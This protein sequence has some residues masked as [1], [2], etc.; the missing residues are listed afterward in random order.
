METTFIAQSFSE[1]D[2]IAQILP[3]SPKDKVS[4]EK[5]KKTI[6]FICIGIM[7]CILGFS[8]YQLFFQDLPLYLAL[9][10][11]GPSLLAMFIL[12][13]LSL[14]KINDTLNHAVKHV[15][16]ARVISKNRTSSAYWL[17]LGGPFKDIKRIFVSAG[18][19]FS[20]QNNDLVYVEV[21][22]KSKALLSLRKPF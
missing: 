17:V 2:A 9:L 4:L 15:S 14:K 6:S 20:V 1:S 16:Y 19:Y 11:S 21:L 3:L 12:R 18:V 10:I 13:Y 7:I 5:Q 8:G 22:P